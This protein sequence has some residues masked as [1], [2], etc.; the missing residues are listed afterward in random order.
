KPAKTPEPF[1]GNK[2]RCLEFFQ[3]L[4]LFFAIQ[5]KTY[6]N[7]V[8]KIQF[9]GSLMT[10]RAA[11][12]FFSYWPDDTRFKKFKKFKEFYLATFE[13][14]DRALVA[15]HKITNLHQGNQ[16]VATYA[17][18]FLTIKR[19][20]EWDDQ[21]LMFHFKKG[22]NKEIQDHLLHFKKPQDLQELIS[23]A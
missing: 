14:H 7:D 6:T 22:L 13:D 8:D 2:D 11:D 9:A 23:T 21:P 10:G 1:D 16:D 18:R 17:S 4:E 19:N 5:E 15:A 3:Q 12:W 20:L